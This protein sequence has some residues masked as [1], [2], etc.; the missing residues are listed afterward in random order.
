MVQEIN[1]EVSHTRTHEFRLTIKKNNCQLAY[2]L[3][4]LMLGDVFTGFGVLKQR[5][6]NNLRLY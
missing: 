6:E 4:T 5:F 2:I 1:K 3:L